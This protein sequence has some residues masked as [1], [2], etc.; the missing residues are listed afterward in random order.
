MKVFYY[1]KYKD[2]Q[3]NCSKSAKKGANQE[4]LLQFYYAKIVNDFI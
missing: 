1:K 4:C 2:E 3:T